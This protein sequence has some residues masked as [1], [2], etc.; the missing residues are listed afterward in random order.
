MKKYSFTQSITSIVCVLIIQ[1]AIS[2][3]NTNTQTAS[4]GGKAISSDL[5][6][7]F[8]EDLS[9]A[10]DG[11]L[12]AELIQ[13]RSFEYNPADKKGWDALTS[14]EYTTEGYGYGDI[15]VET[16]YPVSE[17][18]PHYV[19]LNVDDPGQG[20]GLTNSGFDG[21]AVKEG[22]QYNFSVFLKQFSAA[23]IPIQVRL[24]S[25]A[26]VIYS[27]A[28]LHTDSKDWKKYS[29]TFTATQTDPNAVLVIVSQAKGKFGIDM[30][31]LFP[32]KTFKNRTNGLRQDLGQL[33]ADLKPKFMRFPG[34]CLA[35]GDGVN[36]I[37]HWKNTI[38]PIEQRIEQR[39]IWNYHQTLGLGYFEYFQFC[40]DIGAKPI[41]IVAAGVSCQN[42]GGS[43]R[44]GS[45]GQCG[46][47]MEDMN[48]YIQDVLDLI[49]YA[50]GSSTS[51]WGAK[52]ALAGHPAP[53]NL[54]YLGVGNEDKMTAEFT[55]RFKMIYEAVKKKYPEIKVIGTVGADPSGQ[56][57]DQ[58]WK[59]ANELSIPIVDEHY[60]QK[61]EWFL[62]NN[63]RYDKFNRSK[64][65][66][67]IGEYASWGN[68][69]SNALAEASYMTSMER[70]GDV[71]YMA[72][73]APLLAKVSHESWNPNLIYFTNTKVSPTVN[74]YV[75]KL[76][77]NNHGDR[78]FGNVVSFLNSKDIKDSTQTASCVQDST[79]GDVILKIVNDVPI[80]VKV[81]VSLSQFGT[82]ENQA[83]LTVLSGKP[84]AKNSIEDPNA[85]VPVNS[86]YA[87]S[88]LTL[89]DAPPY[90][91]SVIRIKVVKK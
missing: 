81:Q 72:S 43:W 27:Q 41:P 30:A 5:F 89:Y 45:T 61:P 6:G 10:A 53:F 74:Y 73:Y 8:F 23:G 38:G 88:K 58:G 75:Q 62:N 3:N 69:L 13:N 25:K 65:K 91:L 82:I 51:E 33:I 14:W 12:Y 40:E 79:T 48:Q 17:Q 64:S 16:K 68:A 78:Y 19:V 71:V 9:Y 22:E 66:V 28:V 35:H 20:V 67:Y 76:F 11:G 49:E 4:K 2:Q 52:R 1:T 32:K 42:S 39:N 83:K 7:I 80:S 29:V 56:E 86:N 47:P 18:N 90:S 31:S 85:I 54:E 77:S 44:V 57:Y 70:N 60:Y 24:Q 15:S 26:G 84:D 50:N 21:I 37:Y 87:V 55:E 46:I 59:L 63:T 36:N 34:G